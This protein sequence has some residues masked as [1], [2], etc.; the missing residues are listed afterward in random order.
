MHKYNHEHLKVIAQLT[1]RTFAVKPLIVTFLSGELKIAS[2]NRLT[3]SMSIEKPN[4]TGD[5]KGSTVQSIESVE[6]EQAL[7]SKTRLGPEKYEFGALPFPK[8]A[9]PGEYQFS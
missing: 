4:H 5:V 3:Q 7:N 1:R 2:S 9:I 8:V 6:W